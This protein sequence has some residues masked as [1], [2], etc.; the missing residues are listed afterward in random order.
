MTQDEDKQKWKT[1]TQ[2]R[3]LNSEQF[4]SYQKKRNVES[5]MNP[6]AVKE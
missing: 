4:T 2:H 3:K 1:H 5:G 6:G